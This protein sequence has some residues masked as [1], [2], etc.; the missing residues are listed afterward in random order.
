MSDRTSATETARPL[1]GLLGAL[2]ILAGSSSLL[3]PLDGNIWITP[4]LQVVGVIWLAGV[5]CRLIALPAPVT[6]LVQ[7]VG[8]SLAITAIFSTRGWLGFIPNGQVLDQLGGLVSEAWN[9]ILITAPPAPAT[10]ELSF[11]I[12]LTVGL[13]ALITDF[14]VVEARASALVAL[15]LLCLYSVPASIVEEM[16]PW[17]AFALPAGMYVLLLAAS[18]HRGKATTV[19]ARMGVAITA[20]VAAS[21]AISVSLVAADSVESVGTAGRIPRNEGN[22]GDVG[23]S[24]FTS[25]HGDLRRKDPVNYLKISGDTGGDYLRTVGLETWTNGQGWS[26]GELRD[27]VPVVSALPPLVK[28]S[29]SSLETVDITVQNYKDT[30]LPVFA[31]TQAVAGLGTNWF[32]DTITRAVHR[33]D[34]ISPADYQLSTAFGGPSAAAL[35]GDTVSSDSALL[36]VGDLPNSV[37]DV[38]EQVTAGA[39]GPYEKAQRLEEYFTDPTNGFVYSLTVPTGNSGDAL[40]D[41][42]ELKKG[43]CEQYASAMAVM[44]RAVGVPSRVAIGFTGGKIDAD[45][46]RQ[47]TSHEAHAWVEVKFDQSGWVRFDPTPLG[48]GNSQDPS[49]TES[50]AAPTTDSTEVTTETPTSSTTTTTRTTTIT[51]TVTVPSSGNQV[52]V[53]G[54][55]ETPSRVLAIT[56][57]SLL[58]LLGIAVVVAVIA[59]P[60]ILRRRRTGR[61]LAVAQRGTAGAPAAWAEIEDLALDH[62]IVFEEHLS[63]RSAANRLARIGQL[64]EHARE[65]LRRI[66]L[67]TEQSWYAA[68]GSGTAAGGA[69]PSDHPVG[70]AEA[71]QLVDTNAG[72]VA[73][74]PNFAE[75]IGL[76]SRELNQ[77]MPLTRWDKLFP[78]SMRPNARRRTAPKKPG[79]GAA[80][81]D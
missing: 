75:D 77:T 41:F 80:P 1:L 74:E 11:L 58:V 42:L 45:G 53:G 78:R 44:L 61:R 26:L 49:E 65:G 47:I 2:T 10:P 57:W 40:V 69:G 43:Y 72:A 71:V 8:A 5:L 32:L 52:A 36:D 29:D 6:V 79:E 50:T 33:A 15:P 35:A 51:P 9:Q 13:T 31:G 14:L 19:S 70:P 37:R 4:L 24:P 16:L 39:A 59:A 7:V 64:A 55:P 34:P 22:G 27:D 67:A 60:S 17:W 25:L 73:T 81:Q 46:D 48:E 21:L 23:L 56:G 30:F 12:V 38:A 62:G 66:T 63:V 20:V 3:V 54:A 18:G 76:I 28:V 68:P